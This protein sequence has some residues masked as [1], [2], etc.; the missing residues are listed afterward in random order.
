[1]KKIDYNFRS[2]CALGIVSCFVLFLTAAA[3]HRVHHLLENLPYAN[4]IIQEQSHDTPLNYPSNQVAIGNQDRRSHHHANDGDHGHSS[5]R[6]NH[7]HDHGE[8]DHGRPEPQAV[9]ACPG[10][11]HP[12]L[13]DAPLQA[14][15]P[16]DEAHHDKSAQTIC[17]LQ[18]AAQLSHVSSFELLEIP[19]FG[20]ENERRAS[21]PVATFSLHNPSP[22]SQRAPPAI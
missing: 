15:T 14:N 20:M 1:V 4:E 16:H 9:N 10:H 11:E 5:H 13:S 18:A 7:N 21:R 22:F 12:P 17:L 8:R 19:C 2:V 6:N 3:P